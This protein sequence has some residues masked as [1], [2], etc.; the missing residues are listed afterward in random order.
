MSGKWVNGGTSFHDQI[1]I[2]LHRFLFLVKKLCV[3][4]SVHHWIRW[5]QV[6]QFPLCISRYLQWFKGYCFLWSS[7]FLNIIEILWYL[8]NLLLWLS[9]LWW[10][11]WFWYGL[12][13]VEKSQKTSLF[14]F[15]LSLAPGAVI[16]SAL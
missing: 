13:L 10:W 12:N 7:I 3:C 9:L 2:F 8:S 14:V 15:F 16:L 4:S 6:L 1:T 5:R 11:C